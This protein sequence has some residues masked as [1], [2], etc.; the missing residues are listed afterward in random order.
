MTLYFV[1]LGLRSGCGSMVNNG[2]AVG[3]S[4]TL[5]HV[6]E[7]DLVGLQCLALS[8]A[9]ID[10]KKDKCNISVCLSWSIVLLMAV[11]ARN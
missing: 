1:N 2:Y 9:C 4:Q 11:D 7:P 6:S 8:M 10:R 3:W 5:K